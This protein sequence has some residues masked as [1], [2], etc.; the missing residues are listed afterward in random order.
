MQWRRL[1]SMGHDSARFSDVTLKFTGRNGGTTNSVIWLRNGGG[2]TSLLS[3]FFAGV[4][5]NKREFLGQRA[6]EK[7]RSIDDY[8]GRRDHGLVV[9]E[10]ELDA[11]KT[12]FDDGAPRYLSGVFYEWPKNAENGKLGVDR[13]F[14]AATSSQSVPELTLDDLPIFTQGKDQRHRR[15]LAG[16]RRMLNQLD[17][18]HPQHDVFHTDKQHKFEDELSNHGIDPE[19]FYYQIRMNEREGGV[20]ERFSFAEDEEFVDFLLEMAFSQ[21][22]AQEVRDQLTTFRQ[23]LVERNEQLKPELEYCE[24]LTAR[25]EKLGGVYRDRTIVFHETSVSHRRLLGLHQ[26]VTERLQWLESEKS[27]LDS[28]IR[29]AQT[30]ADEARIRADKSHR[31]ASVFNQRACELRFDAVNSEYKCAEETHSAAKRLRDIWSAACPLARSLDARRRAKLLREQLAKKQQQYAPDLEKLK[32]IAT[33]LAN[34]FDHRAGAA[35]K[36]EQESR[37]AAKHLSQ[38]AA[39][40][41]TESQ[42][43]LELAVQQESLAKTLKERLETARSELQL[44]RSAGV[45]QETD[46][47]EDGK[48]RLV[49]ETKSLGDEIASLDDEIKKKT[50]EQKQSAKALATAQKREADAVHHLRELHREKKIAESLR[51]DLEADAALLRLLQVNEVDVE[52]AAARA[53]GTASE[54]LRRITD[55]VLRIRIESAEDER[56]MDWLKGD[57]EILPPSSDVEATLV[58]LHG[59]AIRAWSGWEYIE[60]NTIPAERRAVAQ[61]LPFAATGIVVANS[62]YEQVVELTEQELET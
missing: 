14:F 38:Q 10:W 61:E 42:S 57:G 45:L 25:L 17:G 21:R 48:L 3:L 31:A 44:L 2:K 18:S 51:S 52:S 13:L 20:S 33:Q 41:Q 34:A 7:I 11:E 27:N 30:E 5:P 28:Q 4:R 24:G 53:I 35:R 23:E 1:V 58:W 54:E 8:V 22:R 46:S 50:E 36:Q 16:F 40:A 43:A 55:T 6:E 9:C 37:K 56:A 29:A 49:A 32:G 19:V 60:R 62:D 15:T 47:A 59:K 39:R 26:W 12:L